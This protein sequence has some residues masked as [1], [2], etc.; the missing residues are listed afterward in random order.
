MNGSSTA[1]FF[2]A[3][4]IPKEILFK[5][6]G[7]VP[8]LSLKVDG[9]RP[10]RCKVQCLLPHE[11]IHSLADHPFAFKSLLAGNMDPASIEQFWRHCQKLD[12]WSQH[13]I[14]SGGL[15]L[16]RMIPLTIH[17]DGA[18]FYREDEMFTFSISSLFAPSGLI[19]DILLY[20]FPFLIIPERYMRSES[21]PQ[22]YQ[23]D[24]WNCRVRTFLPQTMIE[25]ITPS[26]LV[27]SL[28][29]QV[30]KQVNEM[31][32]KLASW[33]IGCAMEGVMPSAGFEGEPLTGHRL[34]MKGKPMAYGW[35][36]LGPI[37]AHKA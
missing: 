6:M 2:C 26:D 9:F 10:K 25:V 34:A 20:K 1:Q 33:S 28:H 32:A 11:I 5:V 16:D 35:R 18:Q 36:L 31:A 4:R 21:V 29:A 30:A 8:T 15:P 17:G 13:P 37:F 27:G 24:I 23:K 14:F 12:A 3:F 7:T 19:Q 22:L